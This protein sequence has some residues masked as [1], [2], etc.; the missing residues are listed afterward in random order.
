MQKKI[1][2]VDL[3]DVVAD[4]TEALRIVANKIPGIDLT[5]EHYQVDGKYWGY[6]EGVWRQNGVDH[7]V[8]F[9]SLHDDMAS[10]QDHVQIIEG[11]KAALYNLSVNYD[12][13]AVTSRRVQWIESTH[14]WLEENL[15]NVFKDIVFVHHD[16]T[17]GRTKGDACVEIGADWLID[18]N[19]EHCQSAI[20]K[21]TEAVLF[22]DCGWNRSIKL[23]VDMARAQN[24][25]E[26]LEYFDGQ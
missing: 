20:E 7:L 2:A 19:P 13:V 17:D 10:N 23:S 9:D 12:L 25:Q 11:A 18:D 1:I 21:G 16:N 5:K 8:S 6:Y 15:P 22:G 3:D 4:T 24:W 26:V 14:R